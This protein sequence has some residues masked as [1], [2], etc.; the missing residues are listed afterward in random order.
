MH[1]LLQDD[2]HVD[3]LHATERA[4]AATSSAFAQG[5]PPAPMAA[6][7]PERVLDAIVALGQ[8]AGLDRGLGEYLDRVATAICAALDYRVCLIYLYDR[9][10]DTYYAEATCGVAPEERHEVLATPVPT[11]VA[12]RLMDAPYRLARGFYV[13]ASAPLWADPAVCACFAM[14]A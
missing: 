5:A 12:E 4:G 9:F 6:T 14:S 13:R 3:T 10:D 11:R 2:T 1:A 7:R 8:V